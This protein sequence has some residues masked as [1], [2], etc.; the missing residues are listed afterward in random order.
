M[1]LNEDTLCFPNNIVNVLALALKDI[2][3]DENVGQP[4]YYEGVRVFKR[5][6]DRIDGDKAVSVVAVNWRPVATSKE[7]GKTAE[8][9]LQEYYIV[10]QVMVCDGE[11]ER[12]IAT[13]SLLATRVRHMLYRSPALAV[14]LPKLEVEFGSIGGVTMREKLVKWDVTT[15]NFLNHEINGMFVYLASLEMRFTTTIV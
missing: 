11:E 10:V 9:I 3:P 14:V 13:H 4:N 2:D 1:P 8:H 12:A 5:P 15:Q 6:L 7:M